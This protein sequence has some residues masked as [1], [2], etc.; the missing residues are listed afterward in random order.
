MTDKRETI[1]MPPMNAEEILEMQDITKNKDTAR[2]K[3]FIEKRH[4]EARDKDIDKDIEQL[5]NK[6]AVEDKKPEIIEEK[7][8]KKRTP[9]IRVAERKEL[10]SK[11]TSVTIKPS[12]EQIHILVHTVTKGASTLLNK[13]E[14]TKDEAKPFSEV[15]YEIGDS[16]KW[17]DTIEFLPYLILVFSGIDLTLAIMKKPSKV[18]SSNKIVEAITE[19][20]ERVP[21]EKPNVDFD[22]V[23]EDKL[24]EKLGGNNIYGQK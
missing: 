19:K 14:I 20:I 6:A 24:M 16:L 3:A 15:L 8:I 13:E 9:K 1:K 21:D 5:N 12:P 22:I 2:L 17:W 18:K 11:K 10:E 4:K 7:P 23:N